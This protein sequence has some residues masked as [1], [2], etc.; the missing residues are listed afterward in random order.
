MTFDEDL[1]K[2]TTYL[3]SSEKDKNMNK[4]VYDMISLQNLKKLT[5]GQQ[6]QIFDVIKE[7]DYS[8]C[9]GGNYKILYLRFKGFSLPINR[10]EVFTVKYI[11]EN[12]V[13]KLHSE[14]MESYFKHKYYIH[15]VFNN[16]WENP[17]YKY[18]SYDLRDD[19]IFELP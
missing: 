1:D 8:V 17:L 16:E 15:K 3:K 4:F 18:S 7:L 14:V 11:L 5:V 19:I 13:D 9:V 6:K 10:F 12:I 2:M